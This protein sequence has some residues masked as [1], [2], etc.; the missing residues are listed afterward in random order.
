MLLYAPFCRKERQPVGRVAHLLGGPGRGLLKDG[1]CS[2][3][4]DG[5]QTALR[6]GHA[7]RKDPVVSLFDDQAGQDSDLLLGEQLGVIVFGKEALDATVDPLAV[8]LAGQL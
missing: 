3:D 6:L 8:N 5:E 2:D 7:R 4:R 1:T